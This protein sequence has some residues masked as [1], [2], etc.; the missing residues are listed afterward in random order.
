VSCHEESIYSDWNLIICVR[1]LSIQFFSLGTRSFPESGNEQLFFFSH[2]T[3][4][5]GETQSITF[6]LFNCLLLP[7]HKNEYI[8]LPDALSTS[9]ALDSIG[10]ST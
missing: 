1:F 4:K 7:S 6:F 5:S 2:L 10:R 8:D 9:L 3:N